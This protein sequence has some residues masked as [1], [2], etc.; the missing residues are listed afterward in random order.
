[1]KS[2]LQSLNAFFH[3]PAFGLF[4]I[5]LA[6]GVIFM[7][8]GWNKFM[9]GKKVLAEVG[10]RIKVVGLDVGSLNTPSFFFG[11][12]AAGTELVCGAL[13]IL[14]LLF[15]PAAF[16]LFFTMVVATLAKIEDSGG[17]LI[18]FGYPLIMASVLVGLFFTG[19]GRLA[20]VRDE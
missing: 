1:M 4:V 6:L 20:L 2:A 8:S 9:A 18:Q 10:A 13:L 7:I 12:M 19:T 11:V 16:L 17:D 14:G 15:R 3:K 5:R